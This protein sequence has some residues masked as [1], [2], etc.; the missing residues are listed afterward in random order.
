MAAKKQRSPSYPGITLQEAIDRAHQFYKKEGKHEALVQTAIPHWGYS[1]KS[2]G[3]LVTIAALKAYGL[4]ADKGAGAERKVFLTP[5]GLNLILDER[6]VSPDRDKAIQQAA[7]T[8]KIMAEMW[9]KFGR[10]LP[11][12]ETLRHYLRV[13]RDFND[14]AVND[15]IKVYQAN[16]QFARLGQGDVGFEEAD[17]IEGDNGD[18]DPPPPP[19]GTN[20]PNPPPRVVHAPAIAPLGGEEIG[21][22]RV[23]KTTTIRLV[24]TGPYSRQSIEGLVKQL[25]LGLDLGNFD[26]LPEGDELA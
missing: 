21:N 22:Y 6:T 15:V 18:A 5:F 13:E 25:Q 14:N 11:S 19:P 12:H 26:D 2:S 1:S 20:A 16:V 24:A 23:S 17:E 4:M 7:L 9:S 8:P 3:G 10:D